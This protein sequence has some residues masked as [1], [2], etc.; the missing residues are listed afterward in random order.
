MGKYGVPEIPTFI[1]SY[2]HSETN[3][4][5]GAIYRCQHHDKK[6]KTVIGYRVNILLHLQTLLLLQNTLIN[7]LWKFSPTNN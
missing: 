4:E 5:K 7:S 1:I 3:L 6:K 2:L